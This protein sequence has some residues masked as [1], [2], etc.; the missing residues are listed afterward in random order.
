MTILS[1]TSPISAFRP[2][3]DQTF[4]HLRGKDQLS[5]QVGC[6]RTQNHFVAFCVFDQ[7]LAIVVTQVQVELAGHTIAKP[8]HVLLRPQAGIR[9]A[10]VAA[11]RSGQQSPLRISQQHPHTGLVR[12]VL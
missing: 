1:H 2:E 4:H 5:F 12:E 11:V 10:Q 6:V 7:V 3:G 8:V 9:T